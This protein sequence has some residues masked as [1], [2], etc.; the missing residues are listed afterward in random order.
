MSIKV[1]PQHFSFSDPG[2]QSGR[3]DFGNTVRTAAVPLQ[4]YAVSFGNSDHHLRDLQVSVTN[5][6][7]NGSIVTYNVVFNLKDGS[8][9]KGSAEIDVTVI[10]D[11]ESA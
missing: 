3:A 4:G 8:N 5:I 7:V 10:G 2:T 1:M 11:V 9:N 6:A